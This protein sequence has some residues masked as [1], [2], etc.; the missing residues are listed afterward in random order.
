MGSIW[1]LNQYAQPPAFPGGTRH[2]ELARRLVRTG[3]EVT[4]ICSSFHHSS[5]TRRHQGFHTMT[6]RVDGVQFV[7]LSARTSYQRNGVA[8]AVNMAEY[9]LR[10]WLAGRHC[11][12]ASAKPPIAIIGTSPHLL[13]AWAGFRLSR[14]FRV[15]FV[16][17]IRDLWPETFVEMGL[18]SKRHPVVW[19]LHLLE[20]RLVHGAKRLITLLPRVE[21][22]LRSRKL[23]SEHVVVIPNG[24]DSDAFA[25][26]AVEETHGPARIIYVGAHGPANGLSNVLEAARELQE[27]TACEFHLFGAG[28]EKGRLVNRAEQLGLSNVAF[29]DAV[30]KSEVP[31]VLCGADFLL[32]NYAPI[33]IGR[34]GISPN[35]LWEYMA[36]G[37]PVVFAHDA[38]NNPVHDAQCGVCVEPGSPEQLAGAVRKLCRMPVAERQ[39]M[40]ERGSEYAREH[41]DWEQLAERLDVV[42]RELAGLSERAAD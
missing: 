31:R 7:W 9:A 3:H 33:G 18:L 42:I 35:K 36:A 23:P 25:C 26:A 21:A 27:D 12:G 28:P 10:A 13:A 16:F 22:Y 37:R 11:Y 30:P 41:H 20:A 4:V 29:H 32:L 38:V 6:E 19:L 15:P 17:E 2:Y 24:V 8:R 39:A 34:Y 40:G 5:R 1:I 14:K